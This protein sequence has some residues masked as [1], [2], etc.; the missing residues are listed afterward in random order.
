[1]KRLT[2]IPREWAAQLKRQS[3]TGIG[4]QVVAVTL[5]DGK[6]F[7]QVLTSEGCVIQV[8]GYQEVPFTPD[9]VAAVAVN[10][11]RWNFRAETHLRVPPLAASH[12]AGR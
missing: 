6:H 3:D 4:Y 8:R 12:A 2:P 7:D 9:D 1:M 10:H 5:K 11:K